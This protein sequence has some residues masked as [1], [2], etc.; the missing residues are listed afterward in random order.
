M[1]PFPLKLIF[2]A[3]D[4]GLLF[5]GNTRVTGLFLFVGYFGV[6]RICSFCR[7]LLAKGG[8]S[9]SDPEIAIV[10]SC[11]FLKGVNAIEKAFVSGRGA[12]GL[13]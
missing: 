6:E 13:S 7:L 3:Y 2:K 10:C 4:W 9:S 8:F 12:S 11:F 5:W 1:M